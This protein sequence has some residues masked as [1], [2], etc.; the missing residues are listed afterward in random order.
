MNIAVHSVVSFSFVKYYISARWLDCGF[1]IY[2]TKILQSPLLF[3]SFCDILFSIC[4]LFSLRMY[5]L[6]LLSVLWAQIRTMLHSSVLTLGL[7]SARFNSFLAFCSTYEDNMMMYVFV[8]KRTACSHV[9]C[10][11]F[12]QKHAATVLL[13]CHY[14]VFGCCQSRSWLRAFTESGWRE[15]G[16]KTNAPSP[17]K[18]FKH[19]NLLNISRSDENLSKID[20]SSKKRWVCLSN[21]CQPVLRFSV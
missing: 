19:L 15:W 4:C 18:T 8:Q 16:E 7:A 20:N 2:L 12:L 21:N 17:A 5:L 10:W 6:Q 1:S 11:S 9:S 13:H 14:F 3:V